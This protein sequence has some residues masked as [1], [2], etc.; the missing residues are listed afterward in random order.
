M[1]ALL[2]RPLR[3]PL[4]LFLVM[5][6]NL[7][8][9]CTTRVTAHYQPL[10]LCVT[11]PRVSAT[12]PL[13]VTSCAH[14][15]A[16]IT[17]RHTNP[18]RLIEKFAAANPPAFTA[19]TA[20]AGPTSSACYLAPPAAAGAPSSASAAPFHAYSSVAAATA[21]L[22]DSAVPTAANPAIP[23]T[24]LASAPVMPSATDYTIPRRLSAP[25]HPRPGTAPFMWDEA[26]LGQWVVAWRY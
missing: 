19:A 16:L 5:Y 8:V 11:P 20:E 13:T 17:I 18:A 26:S 6:F 14:K 9:L 15:H 4:Y 1:S 2:F 24:A 10:P 23:A 25:A 3:F 12:S 22:T 7:R 21:I